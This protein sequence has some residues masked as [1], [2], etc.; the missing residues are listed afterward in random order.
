MSMYATI[1]NTDFEPLTDGVDFNEGQTGELDALE[2]QAQRLA[3]AGTKCC[4][5][6][7]RD[8]DGQVAYWGPA[9]ATISTET[10]NPRGNG[11]Q[12]WQPLKGMIIPT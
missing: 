1:C 5:R 8:S 7:S 4:I 11:E 3:A 2:S 10:G 6:W 9:G 12:S